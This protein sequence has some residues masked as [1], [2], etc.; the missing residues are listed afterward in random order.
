[1]KPA[2]PPVAAAAVAA[3]DPKKSTSKV[4]APAPTRPAPQATV[5]IGPEKEAAKPGPAITTA[6]PSAEVASAEASPDK[7]LDLLAIAATV[8]ALASLGVQ[9]WIFLAT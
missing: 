1:M 5:K 7:S 3:A 8:V 4:V 2:A 9:L 6:K